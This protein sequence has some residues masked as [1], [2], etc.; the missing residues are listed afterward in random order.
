MFNKR[1]W[2][3]EGVANVSAY[4]AGPSAQLWGARTSVMS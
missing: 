2:P 4:V 3:T 1:K